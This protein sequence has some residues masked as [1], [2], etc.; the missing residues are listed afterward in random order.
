[1]LINS[2]KTMTLNTYKKVKIAVAFVLA[3][4]FSQALVYNNYLIPIATMI[5]ASLILMYLR[6]RVKGIIADERDYSTAGK[7]SI[8]AVQIYSWTAAIS[9][10]ILYAYR[11]FNPA[12]EPVALTLAY[13]T[14]ILLILYSLIFRYYNTFKLTE[15]RTLYVIAVLIMLLVLAV[16]S[17]RLF[18]GEDNWIC[19]DGSWQKH[20]QPSFPAPTIE[21]K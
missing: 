17:L 3:L 4:I 11:D 6:R 10:F 20:G 19:V 18:S 2:N 12:Y 1:M 21:C 14:C 16:V 13:S 5:I 8:L 7:A 9:M 15:K